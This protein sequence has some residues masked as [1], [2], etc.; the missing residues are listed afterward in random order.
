MR[1]YKKLCGCSTSSKIVGVL[2]QSVTEFGG[3]LLEIQYQTS[4][5]GLEKAALY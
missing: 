4:F 5:L 1:M 3:Q 2:V